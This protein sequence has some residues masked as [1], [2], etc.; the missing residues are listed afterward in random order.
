MRPQVRHSWPRL[1]HL[2]MTVEEL[3]IALEEERASPG[4]QSVP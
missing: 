1:F 2:G 3:A 4:L